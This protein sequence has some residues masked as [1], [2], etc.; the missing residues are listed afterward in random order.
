MAE[1]PQVTEKKDYQDT[2]SDED[3]KRLA[4]TN[5][6]NYGGK[7][8]R[9]KQKA[10]ADKQKEWDG[11]GQQVGTEVWRIEKF[12]VVKQEGFGGDFYGGDSYI[13]LN[14]YKPD[15][16]KELLAY[17]A[18]FWLG[19]HT[20]QDEAGAAAI[21]T[22]ELD[23]K[24]G[25]L[26]V[27]YREVQGHES[28]HFMDLWDNFQV[29]EGGVETGFKSVKPTE[30]KPR[31]VWVRK[32]KGR[33]KKTMIR[34]VPLS[35]ESLHRGDAFVLDNGLELYAF[36]PQGTSVHE[37]T[38]SNKYIEN[39]FRER[40]GRPKKIFIDE[41]DTDADAEKFWEIVG[42]GQPRPQELPDGPSAQQR[43]ANEAA[44]Y[45]N[46]VNKMFHVT[47]ENGQMEVSEVGSG[48]LDKSIL[49]KERDDVVIVDVGRVVFIWIGRDANKNEMRA[50]MKHATDYLQ[51]T[52]RPLWTSVRR[53][54]DGHEPE[55]F[56]KCF[57]VE[58][59]EIY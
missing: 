43:K 15:P 59:C 49:E 18:H 32:E 44:K 26:P 3:K 17:N 35:I 53:V 1:A 47:D 13:V 9:D 57:N 33:K 25:D 28:K 2:L 7:E 23:D 36:W 40:N 16:E 20:T 39:I 19:E 31:L 50:A 29:L 10:I 58:H 12:K 22:V 48:V 5:M 55:D 30:Y 24:L 45:A 38:A 41:S 54:I 42:Q 46:H 52:G 56:W 11:C 21:K 27:Q 8:H 34:E 4:D 37:K 14:T 51:Q 6:E